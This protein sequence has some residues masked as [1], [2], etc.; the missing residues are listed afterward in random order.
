MRASSNGEIPVPVDE[1][2]SEWAK[3]YTIDVAGINSDQHSLAIGDCFWRQ[4]PVGL[5]RVEELIRK[6]THIVP[7]K[8]D[9]WSIYYVLFS[10][11]GWTD[12]AR[13]KSEKLMKEVGRRRRWQPAG[14]RLLS[15]KEVD[16]DLVRWSL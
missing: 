8:G 9:A 1:V 5:D 15:L 10:A 16:S 11:S 6:T 14:I 7:K 4:T 3:S 2:G 12:E 13:N